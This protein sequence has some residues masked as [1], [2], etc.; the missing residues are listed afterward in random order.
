MRRLLY[1]VPLCMLVVVSLFGLPWLDAEDVSANGA[2]VKVVL[3]YLPEM[4]NFGPANATGVAEIVMKEGTVTLSVVGLP[5][6]SADTYNGWLLNT[7]TSEVLNV[8]RFNT[9]QAQ[10]AKTQA[11]LPAEIPEK[12]WNLFLVTVETKGQVS[13]AP[14]G[15]KSI[16]GYFPDSA[17]AKRAPAQLPKTGGDTDPEAAQANPPAPPAASKTS[18]PGASGNNA[19]AY[20]AIALAALGVG[21]FTGRKMRRG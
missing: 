7:R 6:L 10:T 17:E 5:P 9:D 1:V 18:Q 15:R 20:G 12:G 8:A 4:S 16:G 14:G 11:V 21:V 3:T 2:P 13:Q 19:F